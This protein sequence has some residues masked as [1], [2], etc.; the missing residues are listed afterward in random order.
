[1]TYGDESHIITHMKMTIEID[2][3]KL[4]RLMKLT[5]IKTKTKALNYALSAA[6]RS[7]MRNKLLSTSLAPKDLENAIDPQYDLRALRAREKPAG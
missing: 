6:E 3:R 2:E 5:G 4:S 1:L 7:A